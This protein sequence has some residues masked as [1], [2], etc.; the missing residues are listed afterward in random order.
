MCED[1]EEFDG[2]NA[3]YEE[4]YIDEY[5]PEP[6]GPKRYAKAAPPTILAER[7]RYYKYH[8]KFSRCIK[9]LA[10]LVTPY[11]DGGV[12]KRRMLFLRMKGEYYTFTPKAAVSECHSTTMEFWG[13]MVQ[14]AAAMPT[15]KLDTI[16]YHKHKHKLWDKYKTLSKT[17][18]QQ[19]SIETVSIGGLPFYVTNVH[20]DFGTVRGDESIDVQ[21]TMA[22]DFCYG[23]HTLIRKQE[24]KIKEQFGKLIHAN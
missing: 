20:A 5:S 3:D 1:L 18:F 8:R 21:F 23:M 7:L 4:D 19:E 2:V 11:Q 9:E 22:I 15:V 6:S 10:K 14:V 12:E 16:L 24:F 17:M 13:H